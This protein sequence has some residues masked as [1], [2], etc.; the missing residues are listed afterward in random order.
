M[1]LYELPGILSQI[2]ALEG[3]VSPDE[4]KTVLRNFEGTLE[5]KME[6]IGK[7]LRGME[8]EEKALREEAARLEERAR[9][10]KA[11]AASLRLYT[12]D[13]LRE[14]GR[15]KVRTTLFSFSRR[16]G[17]E[18]VVV[19]RTEA[20][21]EEFLAVDVKVKKRELAEAIRRGEVSEDVA[22]LVPGKESLVIR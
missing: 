13:C 2:E 19:Y 14:M 7:A 16:P 17:R 18:K 21:P 15:D 22:S 8:L 20:V 11:Q 9:A 12:T 6:G 3:Q 10:V 5:E 4:Y 1:K